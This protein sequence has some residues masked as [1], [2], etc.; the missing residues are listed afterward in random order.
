VPIGWLLTAG[1]VTY[2]IAVAALRAV[3]TADL[4]TLVGR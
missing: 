3:P 2:L 4:R 1:A